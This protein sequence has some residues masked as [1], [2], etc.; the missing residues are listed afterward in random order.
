MAIKKVSIYDMDGVIVCSLHRYKTQI[1]EDGIERINL[2]HWR[3]N[4][5]KAIFDSL[6]PLSKQYKADLLNP[7]C[8]VIIATA[9]VLGHADFMFINGTLGKPHYLISRDADD[10]QSGAKL[11]IKGL[12]KFFNLKNFQNAEFIMYEDNCPQLKKICD[13]F[14]IKGVYI[15]SKQG[16]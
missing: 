11:K 15:P 4:S 2:K 8:F 12:Q 1:C 7:E 10:T 5:H 16:H 13:Y 14:Q 9:R 6:L 3:D